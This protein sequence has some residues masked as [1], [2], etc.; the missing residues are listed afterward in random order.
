MSCLEGIRRNDRG[1]HPYLGTLK[2]C[3][4]FLG[5]LFS[6]HTCVWPLALGSIVWLVF[7]CSLNLHSWRQWFDKFDS[8][9]HLCNL[10]PVDYATCVLIN[11]CLDKNMNLTLNLKLSLMP[12]GMGMG[13]GCCFPDP[14]SVCP[15]RS[16]F[17]R[18]TR[19]ALISPLS[20]S[21][22][23]RVKE[24]PSLLPKIVTLSLTLLRVLA[25]FHGLA[26]LL[27]LQWM[28]RVSTW[29]LVQNSVNLT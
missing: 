10:S 6:M 13:Y 28:H 12:G 16:W 20:L 11:T 9:C 7:K 29:K 1:I 3:S 26:R 5:L 19:G 2:Y 22:M 15:S 8:S 18:K 21:P 17:S 24:C 14:H 27:T 4:K 25:K 23:E